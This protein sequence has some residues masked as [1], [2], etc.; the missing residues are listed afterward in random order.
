MGLV[1]LYLQQPAPYLLVHIV[2]MYQ[3][4]YARFYDA[5]LGGF[6][7]AFDIKELK[8]IKTKSFASSVYILSALLLPLSEIPLE[9]NLKYERVYKPIR[10]L[11]DVMLTSFYDPS[12]G[13]IVENFSRDWQPDWRDRRDGTNT[14]TIV[15]HNLQFAWVL[16]RLAQRQLIDPSKIN[17]AKDLAATVIRSV[18]K[19]GGAIRPTVDSTTGSCEKLVH[20]SGAAIKPGGS[21]RKVSLP[22]LLQRSW[23]SLPSLRS[24]SFEIR[25]YLS[26]LITFSIGKKEESLPASVVKASQTP[27]SQKGR[28]EKQTTTM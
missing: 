20:L 2:K 26:T 4:F 17:E 7:D 5:E 14:I 9:H 25:R 1:A 22:S 3:A 27:M 8:P 15:G 13:W 21:K 16:L 11:G 12:T 10:Q 6:Y 18:I 24:S 19:Q 28:Q 23:V